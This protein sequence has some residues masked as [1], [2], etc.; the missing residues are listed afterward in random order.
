MVKLQKEEDEASNP[1]AAA[2]S[3]PE[4]KIGHSALDALTGTVLEERYRVGRVLGSGGMGAVFEARHLRLDRPVAIKVLRP[5]LAAELEYIER[6]LREAKAASKIRHRNVV[7]LLDYGETSGGLVYS[8]MEFLEGRDLQQMLGEQPQWRLPWAKAQGLLVQIAS[9]LK[10]AHGQGV[11]H[12]DIKPSNCFLTD[13]D[14]EPVVKL[15]DFGI[16]KLEES[17]HGFALTGT[18]Q[19]MGTPG[20]MAPELMQT[21]Q[22]ASPQSDIYSLGVVAYRM[23]TGQLPFVGE[24]PF[25]VMRKGCFDPVPSLRAVVPELS[26]GVEQ[27]VMQMLAKAPEHRP[28]DMKAVRDRLLQLGEATLGVHAGV[29]YESGPQWS[30]PAGRTV[31]SRPPQSPPETPSAVSTRLLGGS[32]PTGD[33]GAVWNRNDTARATP[34][35]AAPVPAIPMPGA[36]IAAGAPFGAMTAAESSR[37]SRTG[38]TAPF[39]DGTMPQGIASVPLPERARRRW[40]PWLALGGGVVT[41]GALVAWGLLRTDDAQPVE[42]AA[43][44]TAAVVEAEPLEAEPLEAEPDS[45]PSLDGDEGVAPPTEPE[46]EPT[47]GEPA[48]S[49]PPSKRKSKAD[50]PPADAVVTGGLERKIARKCAEEL[51]GGPVTVKF[52]VNESGRIV[53]LTSTGSC[54]RSQAQGTRFRRSSSSTAFKLVVE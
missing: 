12:R 16:A 44:E 31:P 17:G 37:M 29:L 27:L 36:P 21:R 11:I 32:Q 25:E 30:N 14:G 8:V 13:E 34:P 43:V 50:R 18:T 53:G 26:A 54:A 52:L 4:P 23:L 7:E 45:S 22:P 47:E 39:D 42:T 48:G 3:A 6:F 28:A 10:A 5:R 1:G 24:T 40:G 20:Y 35:V 46:P 2:A 41:V 33:H 49:P 38:E 51:E 19:L 15:L 9:G